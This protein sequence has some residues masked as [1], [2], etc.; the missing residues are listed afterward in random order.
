M[1]GFLVPMV[2]E[3]IYQFTDLPWPL[4][5]GAQF[6]CG[7]LAT[8][9]VIETRS[10]RGLRPALSLLERPTRIIEA[11]TLPRL[12]DTET[13]DLEGKSHEFTFY[14]LWISCE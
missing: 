5:P 12:V 6:L 10:G 9:T 13:A 14:S 8:R 11:G 4:G 3:P 1:L 2:H 7:P